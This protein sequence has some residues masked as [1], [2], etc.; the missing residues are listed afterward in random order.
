MVNPR[1]PGVVWTP[2]GQILLTIARGLSS[3]ILGGAGFIAILNDALVAMWTG[4]RGAIGFKILDPMQRV[5]FFVTLTALG[6]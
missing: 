1:E 5:M 4:E 3:Q 2:S 6:G